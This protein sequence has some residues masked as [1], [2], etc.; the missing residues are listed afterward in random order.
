VRLLLDTHAFL[1]WIADDE[2]LSTNAREAIAAGSNEA[3]VS[4][5]STWE[6]VTKS[7]LGRLEIPDPADHFVTSQLE[8]NAFQALS[9]TVRHTLG[10]ASLPDLHRDPFDRML[11]AQAIAEELTLVTGDRAVRAYPVPTIW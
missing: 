7:R 11:V 5:A 4:A 6:I 9:I 8:A 3:F 1:W 10:L 2:R